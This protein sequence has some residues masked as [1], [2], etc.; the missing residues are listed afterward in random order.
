MGGKIKR[1]NE[2]HEVVMALRHHRDTYEKYVN[3]PDAV[4]R[5][6]GMYEWIDR[7]LTEDIVQIELG[8]AEHVKKEEA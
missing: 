6:T 3:R 1:S 5:L 8:K 2:K 4:P 7:K